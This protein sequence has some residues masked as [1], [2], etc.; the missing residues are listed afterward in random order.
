MTDLRQ[1]AQA[2]LE[3]LEEIALAGMSGTGQESPEAM[4]AWHA[5]RAWEFIRIAAVAK[6]KL[7]A[8]LAAQQAAQP[9]AGVH[10]AHL[11]PAEDGG[12]WC[13]EVLLYSG[14]NPGDQ[15]ANGQ[16]VKLYA[17]AQPQQDAECK[18]YGDL[19]NAKWLDPECYGAGAC[20]SLKFKAAQQAAQPV[21]QE[22]I[23]IEAVAE[24]VLDDDDVPTLR[25]LV[26]GGIADLPAGMVL[27]ISDLPL[28]DDYGSGEVFRASQPQQAPL[29]ERPDFVAGYDAGL[30]DGR[31]IAER[32]QAAQPVA[33]RYRE[34]P[35]AP[36]SKMMDGHPGPWTYCEQPDKPYCAWEGV[37][38]E[39]LFAAAQPQQARWAVIGN[40]LVPLP[41]QEPCDPSCLVAAGGTQDDYCVL[42]LGECARKKPSS[43]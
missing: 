38:F 42:T 35:N 15:S 28:T 7:S 30:A 39:P 20:Q 6:E 27:M 22:P 36:R 10:A 12:H 1:A 17:A 21:A 37:E 9:V 23:H 31:R 43:T 3:A 16:R 8:A 5:R 34:G 40:S 25:W 18:P 4:T 41:P 11:H 33:W 24:V 2:A 29:K 13:R 32:E 26:E 19:R 14:G